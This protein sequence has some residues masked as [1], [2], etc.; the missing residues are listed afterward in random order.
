MRK[1]SLLLFILFLSLVCLAQS[2]ARKFVLQNSA[3]GKSDLTVYLPNISD[4]LGKAVLCCPGGGYTMLASDHEG[5]Q[6]AEF[7][8][9][10]GIAYAVL[11]YRMPEGNRDIPLSDAYNAMKTLRDSAE[12]WNINPR[13]VGIMGFSAGGHLASAV[14]THA[15]F[16]V[17]PNFSILFY[18]VISMDKSK[19]HR[20]S[21][22]NFLGKEQDDADM[23][24]QWSSDRAVRPHLV[25]P[26]VVITANDDRLVPPVT[27][28]IA[29]YTAMRKAGNDCSLFVYPTGDH[30]FGFRTDYRHHEQMVSDL[31][32]WLND[33]QLPQVTDKKIACIGNSIT[34]GHGIDMRTSHGYPAL[35]QKQ[36][37]DGWE[38][39]NFGV[40]SRTMLNKGDYPYMNECAWRD[41]LAWQPDIVVIKLGTND[42]KDHHQPLIA[43][44]FAADMQ[45]MIDSLRALPSKPRIYLCTPI[46]AF[47]SSWTI[48]EKVIV[49]EIMPIITKLAKRNKC[50]L[51]DLHSIITDESEVMDDGIHPNEKGVEHMAKVIANSLRAK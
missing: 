33:L 51:I 38:V 9:S 36:M 40:S 25:P 8:N 17:R 50:E 29:Y 35:L 47:K 41:C 15:P 45:Q 28:G 26:A 1:V 32:Y 22:E 18:P 3:D 21:C 4:S 2:T 7:F 31:T 37:G 43:T 34:D 24:K 13:A 23:I 10:R 49:S 46:P 39:R 20:W 14:S 42:S 6:W 44:D 11:R 16:A 30:G 48:N 27:N 12:V 5:H 19:T